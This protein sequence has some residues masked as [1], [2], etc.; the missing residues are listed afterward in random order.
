M[1]CGSRFGLGINVGWV[2]VGLVTVV[3]LMV[4]VVL[5]IRLGFVVGVGLV[6]GVRRVYGMGGQRE[7]D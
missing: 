5:V 7:V 4:Q 6:I 1:G 2:G 3:V